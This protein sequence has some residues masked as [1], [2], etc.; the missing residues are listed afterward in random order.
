M[1]KGNTPPQYEFQFKGGLLPEEQVK[2]KEA[3][4]PWKR[5]ETNKMLDLY[6]EGA[7]PE[8]I[9]QKLGRNPKA[10]KRRLEQFTYNERDRAVR[11]DPL[12][13]VS[14]KGKRITENEQLVMKSH[15][16]RGVPFEAT[17]KVIQRRA[18]EFD[19]KPGAAKIR[20]QKVFA[21]TMDLIL[22]LRYA[23][24]V[25]KKPLVTDVEYNDLVGEELE[26][27][28]RHGLYSKHSDPK[29]CPPRIK[30]LALYLTEKKED[31]EREKK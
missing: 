29:S 16:E 9:A 11:Y 18:S 7:T 23:Y 2:N 14:R 13:R 28:A 4:Q 30:T 19:T 27:G 5:S 25:Y 12:R 6:F 26:Y 31:E 1:T 10:I 8:R 21:P 20:L 24:Y 15:K 17:L 22:A 3:D